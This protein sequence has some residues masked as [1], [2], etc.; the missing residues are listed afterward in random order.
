MWLRLVVII[1]QFSVLTG[2]QLVG[3][4]QWA[5]VSHTMTSGCNN[6]SKGCFI[7]PAEHR[8]I[9]LREAALLQSFPPGYSFCF[10]KGK[11]DVAPMIGHALPPEFI[12]AQA[13]QLVGT[14]RI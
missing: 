2:R 4:V 5:D 3:K 6:L 13:V 8:S 1:V 7:H 10:D 12:E 14:E 9:T 11:G